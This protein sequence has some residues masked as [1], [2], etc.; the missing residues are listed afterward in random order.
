MGVGVGKQ[1]HILYLQNCKNVLRVCGRQQTTLHVLSIG[2]SSDG[3]R[4]TNH[5]RP[6]SAKETAQG[7]NVAP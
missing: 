4:E 7:A 5:G 2:S 1:R 6:E 3:A